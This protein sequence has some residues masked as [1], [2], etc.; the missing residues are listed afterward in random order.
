MPNTARDHCE[1][2]DDGDLSPLQKKLEPYGYGRIHYFFVFDE[3][4]REFMFT[5]KGISVEETEEEDPE[6]RKANEDLASLRGSNYDYNHIR[7]GRTQDQ[8]AV[9]VT[10]EFT[11]C[12]GGGD[13]CRL[14]RFTYQKPL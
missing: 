14:R 2:D 7:V 12:G 9:T 10:V 6:W 5:R 4:G 13:R 3:E 11:E 8:H 1:L